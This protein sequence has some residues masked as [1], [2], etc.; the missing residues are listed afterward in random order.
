[1]NPEVNSQS[2]DTKQAIVQIDLLSQNQILE[3]QK[4]NLLQELNSLKQ[5]FQSILKATRD[6]TW[7]WDLRDNITWYGEGV[8]LLF[9]HDWSE[10]TT[11]I[12]SLYER[13]HPTDCNHVVNSLHHSIT[14]GESNW[15]ARYRFQRDDGSYAW[16]LDRGYIIQDEGG[17]AVRM[18]GSMQ[19]ITAEVDAK[20][21]LRESEEKFRGA[22]DQLAV[23]I[24]IAD[25]AG[26]FLSV[27]K[28][29]PKIFGYSE[30][31]LKS[32]TI[33]DLSHPDEIEGDRKIIQQLL[34]GQPQTIAREKRYLH[35]SGKVIWG[36]VF[37]TVIKDV[38]GEPKYFVGVLEDITEQRN[39]L[40]TLKNNAERLRLVIDAG[41]IGTWDFNPQN[42]DLFWDD[43]CKQMFGLYPNDRVDY[44]IFLQG[45]HPE[46]RQAADKANHDAISGVG[47]G[48]YELEYRTIGLRDQKFRWVRA[49]GRSYK[50]ENGVTT[51]YAGTIIDI[52][53]HKY[54]Q[55]QLSE[56]KERFR[57]LSTTIPQ[58]V[59]TTDREGIVDYMSENW[60]KYTGQI[61]T[62]ERFSFREL[63]HPEDL[64]V[65]LPEWGECLKQGKTFVGEY[66]LLNVDTGKYCWF[67]CTTQP[68]KDSG[69]TVTKWI[70]SATD[71]HESSLSL[72]WNK[73]S[74][75]A[76]K[77][78]K[79]PMNSLKGL[80]KSFSSMLT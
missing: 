78:F 3:S 80:T 72:D 27:N 1:M 74:Q 5:R 21:A 42:G 53:D 54:Y 22:F 58:I 73:W 65:I 34:A 39:T 45:I 63:M 46:D 16:V 8:R 43:R 18:V 32:K 17:N 24:S 19:D 9:G 70:G 67:S 26:K 47:D 28:A 49:K 40:E 51:R 2:T 68:L 10:K 75:S 59:W 76:R 77:I 6:A 35:R 15:S 29:Y 12:T 13:I 11:P 38:N 36:R 31:E 41:K 66:R 14:Q 69:G 71:I 23:G 60:T 20:E 25:P 7:E 37:G 61:P 30:E 48:E 50:D 79:K 52:T 44:E 57:L 55:E 56:Q 64:E 33:S 4:L 62:Y